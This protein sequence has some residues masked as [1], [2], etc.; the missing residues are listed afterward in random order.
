[1][2]SFPG[3]LVLTYLHLHLHLHL[4]H[5]WDRTG[6][7]LTNYTVGEQGALLHWYGVVDDQDNVSSDV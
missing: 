7:T 2:K 6:I 1:M 3:P 5:G 4:D